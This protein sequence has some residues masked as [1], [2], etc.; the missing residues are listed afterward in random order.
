MTTGPISEYFDW[1]EV[2]S[3]TSA[4]RHAIDNTPPAALVPV[5]QA[6]ARSM[7]RVRRILGVPVIPSSWYRS[8]ALNVVI[9][10]A[11]REQD[12]VAHQLHPH[13][14]VAA[15]ASARLQRRQW[16]RHL[17]QHT[18]G[19]AVDFRAPGYGPPQKVVGLLKSV[20]RDLLIDQLIL[21]N[22]AGRHPWVHVSFSDR[23]R[24]Q[25]LEIDDIGTRLA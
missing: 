24:F 17:S 14:V 3:S 12:L 16:G 20:M 9:G 19:Q 2:L 13:P 25:A 10:G 21:E 11:A 5:L 4:E 8:P 1:D 23:P 15:V 22:F 6:T 18:S 7:D